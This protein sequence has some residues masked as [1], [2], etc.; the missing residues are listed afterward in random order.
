MAT[1]VESKKSQS[2]WEPPA[3]RPLDEAVWQAWVAKGRAHEKRS[4]ARR[5]KGLKWVVIAGLLAAAAL[6]TSR[7]SAATLPP[8]DL[9]RYREFRLGSDLPTVA[10]QAG[11]NPAQV[12]TVQGRPALIQ[13]LVWS[14][15]PVKWSAG[16]EAVQGVTFGFCDGVLYR[17]EAAYSRSAIE[18]LTAADLVEAI[19]ATYGAAVIPPPAAAAANELYGDEQETVARW[20]DSKYRFELIRAPYGSGFKLAGAATELEAW[21]KVSALEA[22]MLDLQEAPQR[23][24]DRIASEKEAVN[25]RLE[26]ARIVNRPNFRP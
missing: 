15:E 18:G 20:Q 19:S 12:K 3:T 24:A 10:K 5:M 8:G 13:E 7:M 14:P 16:M 9:S 17:I 1:V 2:V 4:N 21:A 11:L 26:K 22:A 23:E 6:W 25:T